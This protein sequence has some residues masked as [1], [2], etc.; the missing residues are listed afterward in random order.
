LW[1]IGLGAVTIAGT[2]CL[3]RRQGKPGSRLGR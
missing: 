3:V 2:L 1:V